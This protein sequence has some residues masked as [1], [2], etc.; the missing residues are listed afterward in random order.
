MSEPHLIIKVRFPVICEV[1]FNI[2][3]VPCVLMHL[4]QLEG[5][6]LF[7]EQFNVGLV[8]GFSG[9]HHPSNLWCQECDNM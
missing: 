1:T 3:L 5:K 9:T 7:H 6:H 8:L 2:E 4:L